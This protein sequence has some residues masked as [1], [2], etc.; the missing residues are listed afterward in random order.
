MTQLPPQPTAL[1]LDV[2]VVLLKSA[3]EIA[4]RF[5]EL[6]GLEPRTIPGRGP[7]DE[8]G[9]PLWERHLAGELTERE[10][11]LGN[12]EVAVSR[13]APLRGQPHLMRA[14]FQHPEI[15]PHRPEA[16]ALL[17]WAREQS[18]TTAVFSNE[19]MDFQGREWVERQEWFELFD[20]IVDATEVGIR[21]P[22]LRVYDLVVERVGI[23]AERC[24]FVDDNPAYAAA[25][26]AAGM[27]SVLLDVLDPAA[28]FARAQQELVALRSVDSAK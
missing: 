27:V 17:R 24:V 3:W 4:D 11:W 18:I 1:L 10:Y 2:G 15:T 8:S 16:L 21:K 9:D 13:G 25:G 14:M 7:F 22:D 20:V 6:C 5:E 19:L 23:P 28:A 26:E 12:A